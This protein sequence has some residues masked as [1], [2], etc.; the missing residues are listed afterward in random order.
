MTDQTFPSPRNLSDQ[1]FDMLDP[2]TPEAIKLA[3]ADAS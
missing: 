2:V 1:I 3:R